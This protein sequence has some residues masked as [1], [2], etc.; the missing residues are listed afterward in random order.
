M[1]NRRAKLNQFAFLLMINFILSYVLELSD[2]T[3][4]A[5]VSTPSFNAVNLISSTLYT[6]SGV[7]GATAIVINTK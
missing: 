2:V 5:R 3:I 6:I 4:V 7:L 1:E